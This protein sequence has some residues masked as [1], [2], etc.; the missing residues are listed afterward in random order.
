MVA[1]TTGPTASLADASERGC[2]ASASFRVRSD[3]PYREHGT[4]RTDWLADKSE[5][6]IRT[7]G[8]LFGLRGR[9]VARAVDTQSPLLAWRRS[10]PLYFHRP[11][12]HKSSTRRDRGQSC[13]LQRRHRRAGP[14]DPCNPRLV[15]VPSVPADAGKRE[16]QITPLMRHSRPHRLSRAA[17][18]VLDHETAA[19]EWRIPVFSAISMQQHVLS[20]SLLHPSVVTEAP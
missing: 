17:H 1:A 6:S 12:R 18:S 16:Y 11:G 3:R 15:I 4:V 20:E 9:S 10:R 2:G 19:V 8:C 14:P 5:L 13:A 7:G